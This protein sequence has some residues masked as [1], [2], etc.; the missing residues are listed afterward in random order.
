MRKQKGGLEGGGGV[1]YK[2][3]V[4]W[5]REF[6]DRFE[7]KLALVTS[8]YFIFLTK[9]RLNILWM[10]W[11]IKFGLDITDQPNPI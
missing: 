11:K 9:V 1:S 3:I 4:L 5:A 8:S 6:W 7:K 10:F 2:P